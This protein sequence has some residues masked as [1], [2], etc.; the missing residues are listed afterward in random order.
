MSGQLSQDHHLILVQ[1]RS[2]N[3]RLPRAV[4]TKIARNAMK[5][6]GV[7]EFSDRVDEFMEKRTPDLGAEAAWDCYRQLLREQEQVFPTRGH[8]SSSKQ[9]QLWVLPKSCNL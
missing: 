5:E 6:A 9:N 3:A 8:E 2:K 1:A 7:D 4:D